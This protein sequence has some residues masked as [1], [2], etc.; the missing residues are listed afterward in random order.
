[1]N[2]RGGLGLRLIFEAPLESQLIALTLEFGPNV[3]LASVPVDDVLSL[4]MQ[5]LGL[6]TETL[7][8]APPVQ[9]VQGS[10]ASKFVYHLI[11]SEHPID[12]QTLIQSRGSPRGP[13]RRPELTSSKGALSARSRTCPTS[14]GTSTRPSN[15]S[16]ADRSTELVSS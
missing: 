9:S 4:E 1:M 8:V 10:P 15:F 12:Q 2:S 13:S 5:R 6:T 11:K 7:G 3:N 14:A 16:T